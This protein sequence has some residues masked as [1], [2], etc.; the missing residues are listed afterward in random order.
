MSKFKLGKTVITRNINNRIAED[1]NFSQFILLALL[2]YKHCDWGDCCAEDKQEND[3]AV[4]NGDRIF[5]TY[6]Y[7]MDGTK[8]WII[9]EADRSATTVLFPD[10]Y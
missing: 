6:I 10:E 7:P 1:K 9:T 8:I 2:K 4:I 3:A 5:A